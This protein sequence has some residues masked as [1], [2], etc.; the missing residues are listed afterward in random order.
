MGADIQTSYEIK[1]IHEHMK[2][3]QGYGVRKLCLL[4]AAIPSYCKSYYKPYGQSIESTVLDPFGFNSYT[5][6]FALSLEFTKNIK[7]IKDM[8]L[9]SYAY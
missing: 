5:A 9:E 4:D 1:A 6:I 2:M 7:C 3:Y 8:E